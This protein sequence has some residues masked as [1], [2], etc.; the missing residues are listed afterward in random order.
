MVAVFTRTLHKWIAVLLRSTPK[1]SEFRSNFVARFRGIGSRLYPALAYAPSFRADLGSKANSLGL[2]AER[3][4]HR[5]LS[6]SKCET[7]SE[8]ETVSVFYVVAGMSMIEA[9]Y[10][11]SNSSS[12]AARSGI[13]MYPPTT[14]GSLESRSSPATSTSLNTLLMAVWSC[15]N[16]A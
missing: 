14:L 4:M 6:K 15:L 16:A 13:K 5:E 9:P 2:K 8:I 1:S 12:D 3:P 7:L 11:F 10:S